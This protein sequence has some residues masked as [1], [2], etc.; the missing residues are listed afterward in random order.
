MKKQKPFE[1]HVQFLFYFMIIFNYL[2]FHNIFL[3][4]DL[5][6]FLCG[7]NICVLCVRYSSSS[8]KRRQRSD[9]THAEYKR[10]MRIYSLL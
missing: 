5:F 8:K 4:L 9:N 10:N 2:I 1:E 6:I 7:R 3:F